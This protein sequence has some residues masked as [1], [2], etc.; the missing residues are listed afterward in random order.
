[1]VVLKMHKDYLNSAPV[2][3]S[4]LETHAGRLNVKKEE[5]LRYHPTNVGKN[6]AIIGTLTDSK[7]VHVH[8]SN[9]AKKMAERNDPAK[10]RSCTIL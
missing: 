3:K 2:W 10:S 9:G 4:K 1:M 5:E 6:D 7:N 8:A